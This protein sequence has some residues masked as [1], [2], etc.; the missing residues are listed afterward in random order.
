[1]SIAKIVM[2]AV[3]KE[4]E[5][6][7][8]KMEKILKEECH[9]KSGALRDSITI[10][11]KGEGDYLVGVDTGRLQSDPRNIGGIDYSRFYHDGHGSYI[12]RPKSAKALRW[13]GSDGAVHFAKSVRIPA[14]AGDPFVKRAVAK[15]PKIG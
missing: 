5:Q 3:G 11:K 9:V 4:V 12:I 2:K 13:V 7:A 6:Y 14:S 8:D 1:M 10:E 15:R